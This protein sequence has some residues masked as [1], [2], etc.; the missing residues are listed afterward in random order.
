M[1][2]PGCRL[3]R[4]F[5]GALGYPLATALKGLCHV[6]AVFSALFL[7]SATQTVH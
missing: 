3:K 2:M 5:G 1:P 7:E 4:G 6:P